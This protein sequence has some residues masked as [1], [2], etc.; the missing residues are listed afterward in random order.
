MQTY[1]LMRIYDLK[2][3]IRDATSARLDFGVCIAVFV[4]GILFSQ[5][6]LYSILET[7]GRVGI[8]LGPPATIAVLRWGLGAAIGVVLLAYAIRVLIQTRAEGPSWAKIALLLTTGWLY[9]SCGS[10]STNL[11]IGVAMF[12]IFHA[13]Q[14]YAIVWSY[15]RRL[16]DRDGR[17]LGTAAVHVRRGMAAAGHVRRGNRRLRIDQV[18]HRRDRRLDRRRPFCWRSCSR[19]RRCISTTTDS[20]GR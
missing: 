10:V 11:L 12:E 20:S 16:A 19:R 6:R 8:P 3:G 13:A 17:P 4:A 14:Y 2:R 7:V 15:N 9:W 1:G 18:V 5:T